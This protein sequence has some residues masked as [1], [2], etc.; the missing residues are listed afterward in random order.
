MNLFD[1][2]AQIVRTDAARLLRDSPQRTAPPN[3]S[4][5]L[6]F[7]ELSTRHQLLILERVAGRSKWYR[8]VLEEALSESKRLPTLL[9]AALDPCAGDSYVGSLLREILIEYAEHHSALRGDELTEL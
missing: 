5:R 3:E 4:G 9:A 1:V 6:P 7:G 8:E 2:A